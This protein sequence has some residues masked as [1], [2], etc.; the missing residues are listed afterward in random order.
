MFGKPRLAGL[1]V[2]GVAWSALLTV[3]AQ[4]SS[5][6]RYAPTRFTEVD[7]VSDI[8]GKAKTTDPKLANPWGLALGPF[9]PIWVANNHTDSSTFYAG[10]AGGVVK[11]PLDV[12]VEGGSPTG[13][14]YNDTAGFTV[15]GLPAMYIFDSESG[16]ITA[17]NLATGAKAVK[18]AAHAGA[19][20][21]GLGLL[22]TA[23]GPLLLA[24]D[25]GNGRLDVFDQKFL[26]V[27][28]PA[29]SFA[30]PSLPAGYA[31]FNVAVIGNAVYV[32]Y[33]LKN[34]EDEQAGAGLGFVDVYTDT[35]KTRHR[36]AARG[37]LNAPWAVVKAP[38]S[39]GTFAGKILV[40][41][42]GDGRINAYDASGHFKGALSGKNGRPLSIEGL[43]GLQQ[44]NALSGGS[45]SLWFAAGINGEQNGLLGL[46]RPTK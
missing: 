38:A 1:L 37:A 34:G 45:D 25:F 43:W 8:P 44:G 22:H 42:F 29:G 23:K 21:K 5:P 16:D 24:A 12:A 41:N 13:E 19:N 3:P 18:V 33:A 20:Y 31:P 6:A 32:A 39:F 10:G 26:R 36:F 4:A 2:V 46:I 30:D 35:G 7:L 17:W 14:V 11:I 15:K 40:G 9:T 27:T 28:L